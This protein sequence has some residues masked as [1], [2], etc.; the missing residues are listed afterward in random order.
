MLGCGHAPCALCQLCVSF[1]PTLQKKKQV[2]GRGR[3]R[4]Q[5]ALSVL[6][7]A[8]LPAQKNFP[9]SGMAGAGAGEATGSKAGS[10][11][12]LFSLPGVAGGFP[13]NQIFPK[14]N[15]CVS[16]FSC[17]VHPR[18]NC[19]VGSQVDAGGGW[20]EGWRSEGTALRLL[21]IRWGPTGKQHLSSAPGPFLSPPQ[22]AW[23]AD[24]AMKP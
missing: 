10:A 5:A 15:V 16:G 21:S 24:A 20:G 1:S 8:A 6:W 3:G 4:A 18:G 2:Q 7:A 23:E 22:Q 11:Q 19:P 17:S 14:L 13:T 9:V 12:A